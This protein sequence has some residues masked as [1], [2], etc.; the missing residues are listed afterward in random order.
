MKLWF[1]SPLLSTNFTANTVLA[2]GLGLQKE[3]CS[4]RDSYSTELMVSRQIQSQYFK[5]YHN[6]YFLLII[7]NSLLAETAPP[8][9]FRDTNL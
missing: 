1:S 4:I 5:L 9:P 8:F 3:N 6:R 7:S 2:N